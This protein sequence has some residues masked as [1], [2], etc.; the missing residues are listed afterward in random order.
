MALRRPCVIT[1]VGDAAMLVADTCIVV[2][3]ENAQALAHGI[4]QL[5]EMNPADRIDMGRRAR[6]RIESE[7]T[8][9]RTREK[10]EAVYQHVISTPRTWF[11]KE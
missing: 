6:A 10:F 1:D 7:F 5:L 2:P 8:M 9:D 3:K 4:R 11:V